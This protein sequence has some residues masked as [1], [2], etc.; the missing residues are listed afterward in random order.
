[1]KKYIRWLPVSVVAIG[2]ILL[3][4][5]IIS[6]ER[7]NSQIAL[8]IA[9][10]PA[11]GFTTIQDTPFNLADLKKD[12]PLLIIYFSPGCDLCR[13]TAEELF[14]YRDKLK[15]SFIVMVSRDTKQ[16]VALF[17]ARYKIDQ[18][19]NIMLL[20]DK[21]GQTH[22]IL[23][24]DNIPSYLLYDAQQRLINKFVGPTTMEFIIKNLQ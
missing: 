6:K 19:P 21:D 10:L 15:H 20:L 22:T 12:N 8:K 13:H 4:V 5:G 2:M 11:A 23:G 18:M 14:Q 7:N 24:L 17:A 1:M 16:D 3:S 9:Q